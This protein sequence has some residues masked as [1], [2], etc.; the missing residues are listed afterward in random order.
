MKEQKYGQN[1]LSELKNRGVRDIFIACCDNLSGLSKSINAI[2]PD[3]QVQLCMAHQKRASLACVKR[4]EQSQLSKDL[5]AIYTAPTLQSAE[6][7]LNEM[8]D[9]WQNNY[10]AMVKSWYHNWENLTPFYEY[11]PELR[12]VLYTTNAIESLNSGLRT[13]AK[14]DRTFGSDQIAL[15]AM[16]LYLEVARKKWTMP[17]AYWQLI[18]GQFKMLFDERF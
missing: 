9:K 10:P 18:L 12:K 1:I 2:Y 8:A 4:K 17:I 5:L 16:Y 3:T 7:R 14:R 13:V 11:I 15:N 6:K